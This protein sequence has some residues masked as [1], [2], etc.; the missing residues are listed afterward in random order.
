MSMLGGIEVT[1]QVISMDKKK[2]MEEREKKSSTMSPNRSGLTMIEGRRFLHTH[3]S[4]RQSG[5]SQCLLGLN[6]RKR[7]SSDS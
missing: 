5:S 1:F 2:E 7:F 3:T 4:L 6:S